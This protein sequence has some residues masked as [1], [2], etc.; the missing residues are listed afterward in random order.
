M[1]YVRCESCTYPTLGLAISP[2][3]L[4]R[5]STWASSPRRTI[6]CAQNDLA[7]TMN[8]WYVWHKPWTYLASRLALLQALW[9]E[10]PLLPRHLGVSSGASKMISEPMVRFV[11]TMHLC[12]TNT[13]S[14]SKWTETS[15]H[16]T[17]ITKEFYR[18]S[19]M[20]SKPMVRSAQSMLLSCVKIRTISKRIESSFHLSLVT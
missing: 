13:N 10:H 7:Q 20:I 11:Q 15:L 14:V 2:N 1:W 8:L 6:E 4:N 18:V 19:K 17:H 3:G 9:N 5:A 12:F 16:M